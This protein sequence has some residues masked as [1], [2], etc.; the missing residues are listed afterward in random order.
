MVSGDMES[1]NC[2][3]VH[4]GMEKARMSVHKRIY[5]DYTGI[6]WVYMVQDNGNPKS[7]KKNKQHI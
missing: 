4:R 6:L 5:T 2:I 7:R 1:W 3:Q